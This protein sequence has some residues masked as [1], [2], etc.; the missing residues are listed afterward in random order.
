VPLV[1]FRKLSSSTKS[2]ETIHRRVIAARGTQSAQIKKPPNSTKFPIG[3]RQVRRHCRLNAES[4]G[5]LE[6]AMQEMDFSARA[7]DRVLKVARNPADLAGPSDRCRWPDD[8]DRPSRA[9]N[10]AVQLRD[11]CFAGSCTCEKAA[12]RNGQRI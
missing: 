5:C 3:S 9:M 6:H 11:I 7:H 8:G 2:S 10:S 1:A 12:R 4:T